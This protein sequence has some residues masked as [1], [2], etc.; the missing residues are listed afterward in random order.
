MVEQTISTAAE[1][2]IGRLPRREKKQ[3][4]DEECR[5]ALSE[6]NAARARMLRHE[7]R[8]N[9]EIWIWLDQ[10]KRDLTEIGC[11]H[12][13]EAAARDRASW[14][15]IVDRAMYIDV[16]YRDNTNFPSYMF[17]RMRVNRH[18][19]AQPTSDS[20]R[21]I[22]SL[23]MVRSKVAPLKHQSTSTRTG[24]GT[25]GSKAGTNCSRKPRYSGIGKVSPYRL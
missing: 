25:V 13:W 20:T 17:S 7:T 23:V 3:W 18:T 1:H 11:L 14:R 16:L 6:K 10:V 22:H 24:G 12:G 8:Q 2:N 4:F 19:H 15:I 5:R 9:V 21:K